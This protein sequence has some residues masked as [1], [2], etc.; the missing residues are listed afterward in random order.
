MAEDSLTN[1]FEKAYVYYATE[2]YI[3]I[4]KSSIKSIRNFS[5]LPVIVYL[6]NT[7]KEVDGIDNVINV[8]CGGD[9]AIS[10]DMYVSSNGNF[11]INRLNRNIYN[12]LIQR[13]LVVKHALEN[14]ANTI[15]YIDSDSV[16]TEYVESIFDMYPVE[17]DYP[18][19][20]ESIYDFMCIN[21]R[22]GT[23]FVDTLEY[24]LCNLFGVTEHQRKHYRQTGYFV[25]GQNTL[26]F[27]DEWY[28]MC[29]NPEVLRDTSYYAPFNEE[30]VLNV[31]LWKRGISDG[32][33]YIY[34]NGS[35]DTIQRVKE[36]GFSGKKI[37]H[38]DWF[39]IPPFKEHLLFY[40]GEKTTDVIKRMANLLGNQRESRMKILYIAG[41][42]STG[43]M[44]EF[45]RTRI[46]SLSSLDVDVWVVEYSL[47]SVHYTNQREAIQRMLGDRFVSLGWFSEDDSVVYDK[48]LKIKELV[49][50]EKFDIIHLD[51]S[52]ETYDYFNKIHP[53]LYE[54]LY[55]NEGRSWKLVETVHNSSFNANEN[56]KWI[57][58][59]FMHCST[60]NATHTFSKFN[61]LIPTTVVEYPIWEREYVYDR[62]VEFDS[63]KYNIV[64]I[65]IWTPGKNQK[66]AIDMARYLDELYPN[67]YIFHFIGAL[68]PNFMDYWKPL[69]ENLPNNVKVW[70]VQSDM[71]RF[72][73]W[74][75][76]VLFNSTYELNPV[77][78]KEAVSYKKK[79]LMRNLQIYNGV[80]DGYGSYLTGDLK[81]DCANLHKMV[82]EP[83]K[84]DYKFSELKQMGIDMINFYE[85]IDGVQQ[86]LDETK[87]IIITDWLSRFN[88][89]SNKPTIA[90]ITPIITF[91]DGVKVEIIGTNDGTKYTVELIDANTGQIKYSNSITTY[92]WIMAFAR[93]YVDW[94]IHITPNNSHYRTM[95]YKLELAN[96]NVLIK[97]ESSALGDTLAWIPYVEEFRKKHNCKVY[98][99]TFH[100]HLF[101]E[102]YPEINFVSVS[103]A[104]NDVYAKYE[105]GWFYDS[106]GSVDY[107]RHPNN[108]VNQPLQKTAS[109]ILGL[110]YVEILP[111]IKSTKYTGKI[112]DK[113]FTF[114]MQST[115]QSKYWNHP[116]GWKL[117]LDKLNKF[118]LVG[119]CVDK[120]VS[121]GIEG[122]MNVM[123][124]NCI[125]KTGLSLEDTMGII[126]GAEFHIGISSGLS[127]LAWALETPL[128]LISGFTDPIMEPV[129]NCVR[130]HNPKV[131]NGCFTNPSYKFDRADW[132]WCP[133]HKGTDRQFECTKTIT[134]EDVLNA[135]LHGGLLKE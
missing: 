112:P 27:L 8:R 135:M 19:F 120:H 66:E 9:F 113:Y 92:N 94:N 99:A 115:A 91:S 97:F 122:S 43:G 15:A 3:D 32:L 5:Q 76:L 49:E 82:S 134:P 90:P 67:Q 132:M 117:L 18:Y 61:N 58:D 93:Y 68:A 121:F 35:L 63:E 60:Y 84:I 41:H 24:P 22:G 102:V 16:A 101:E 44:P 114:S 39:V 56:K 111:K 128:V 77:V 28:N 110:D 80:Y 89:K 38:G 55:N 1:K 30:T 129:K 10:D 106:N 46:A 33:P 125:D 62:P 124:D 34:I 37:G 96:K 69:L 59:A 65:G 130:I 12:I 116:N 123:P 118:G 127:W 11:Y 29:V 86:K 83:S 17:S 7:D 95:G 31:L 64:N 107:S 45:L 14:Y 74:A 6:L 73:E 54:F 57:P 21:G 109:D 48:Y 20:T 79:L 42:L 70:D 2:N 98:C 25:A 119:V 26:E 87:Q 51:D 23:Q 50:R 126:S 52:V 81:D 78:L 40:H 13:P 47:Y 104:V 72:Y 71:G 105:L 133:V 100:N 53:D 131:C 88:K 4:V 36:I 75:D 108:F 85:S 103:E